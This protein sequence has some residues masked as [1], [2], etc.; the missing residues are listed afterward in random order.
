M[1]VYVDKHRQLLLHFFRYFSLR[2][3]LPVHLFN[4]FLSSFPEPP[5]FEQP[6]SF[7]IVRPSV[8]T[9]HYRV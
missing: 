2:K 5:Y 3:L 7:L 9:L 4:T 1:Q 8:S 6:H